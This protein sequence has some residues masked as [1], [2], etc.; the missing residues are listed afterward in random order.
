M[1]ILRTFRTDEAGQMA[2]REAWYDEEQAQFVIN[3]GPVGQLSETPVVE[4]ELTPEAGAGLMEAFAE[5]CQEDGYREISPEEQSWLYL[6]FPMKTVEGSARDRSLRDAVVGGL[7][8]HL[9][10]RGLGTVEGSVFGPSRLSIV[11]LTPEPKAAV[12][13]TLS[14]LREYAKSDLT[15]AVIAVAPGAEP[16]KARIKHPLPAKGD[17]PVDPLEQDAQE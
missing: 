3:Q 1:P 10:W 15:K 9:A 17:F 2:F 4:D 13:A 11:V 5:Q 8:G 7:T 16:L 6:R 12:K 14:C